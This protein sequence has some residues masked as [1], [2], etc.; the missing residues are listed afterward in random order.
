[1][2]FCDGCKFN[3]GNY[4]VLLD[5]VLHYEDCIFKEVEEE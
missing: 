3:E 4:C 1:M 2:S 5:D